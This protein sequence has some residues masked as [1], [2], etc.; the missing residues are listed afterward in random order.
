MSTMSPTARAVLDTSA[1]R[2]A[3]MLAAYEAEGTARE[4][5]LDAA[6]EAADAAY[7]AACKAHRAARLANGDFSAR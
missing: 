7:R 5:E 1:A 2:D 4:P 3:A 6:Y